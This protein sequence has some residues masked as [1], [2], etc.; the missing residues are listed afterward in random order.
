MYRY[1]CITISILGR[2]FVL[3]SF[4]LTPLTFPI[5]GVNF[6]DFN[7]YT[8]NW[9]VKF[10]VT[11]FLFVFLLLKTIFGSYT[12]THPKILESPLLPHISVSWC[13]LMYVSVCLFGCLFVCHL[14]QLVHP[15]NPL[16]QKGQLEGRGHLARIRAAA[17]K[18]MHKI[19]GA[20]ARF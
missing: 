20:G 7:C 13:N 10:L 17:G 18:K 14:Q 11:L 15:L 16:G 5:F 3:I 8:F 6:L 12:I 9:G 2:D 4:S 19:E 1:L